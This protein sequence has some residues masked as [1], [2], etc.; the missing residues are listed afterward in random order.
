M[1]FSNPDAAAVF[2]EI[3][4][5]LEVQGGNAF[6]VRA[7]RNG[8][9]TLR[10]LPHNVQEMLARGEPLDA[11][12]GIGKD[13]AGK[14]AEVVATGTCAQLESLR[15][16]IPR[17]VVELLQLPGLG[18][19]RVQALFQTL[20]VASLQ[21]LRE[22][23][24]QGRVH[25]VPGF[26]PAGEK[27]ILEAVLARLQTQRRMP[28]AIAAPVAEALL[29]ALAAVPGVKQA[30][31][32]GSLRRRRDTVGDLDLLV[33]AGH[34]SPV[35]ARFVALP[36]VERVLSHGTTRSSVVLRNG[37]QLDLRAVPPES[38]GAAWLYFTG[39]K[40]HNIALRAIAQ[41]LGL[42]LN[43]YGLFRGERRIAGATEEAVYRSLK[44]PW[45]PP[46][47]REDRGEFDAARAGHLPA[48]LDVA[49]LRGDLH[50][51]T[52]DSDGRDSLEA[53][54]RAA[55]ARG[56]RYLAITDHSPRLGVVHG[57]DAA[58]LAR[59]A[60]AI[61]ALNEKLH[62]ITLLKGVEVDIPGGRRDP[63]C[64]RP[65]SAA[66]D[67]ATAPRDGP[68]LL[69][70]PGPSDQPPAG[71]ARAHRPRPG[72]RDPACARARLLPRTERPA[73]APGPG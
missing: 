33:T 31:A 29:A 1:P 45:I 43:E 42:K 40:P 50:A 60:D 47:L 21:Q 57:L 65:D 67:R 54:A 71:G 56:L 25:G 8:A 35:M 49:Q 59:Q 5:L 30:V 14:I 48:P 16:E 3:A 27:R 6:R 15:R 72:A 52:S 28:L 68:P 23:A 66:P 32:A 19:R 22:A 55:Q 18:P 46:E 11:L 13:L 53:M 24:E 34:D 69:Q 41:D 20:G 44:L 38:F 61:D 7:Y 26:T 36:E 2:D 12:P 73:R 39:S 63:P 10:D 70:H 17:G 62:G 58:R 51:H 9:R 64:F 4:D 37:L